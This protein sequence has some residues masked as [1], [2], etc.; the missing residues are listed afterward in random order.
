[1]IIVDEEHD[2]SFKQNEGLR[3]SA[4]DLSLVRGHL[5]QVPVVLGSATP[6]LESMHNAQAGRFSHLRLTQRAGAAQPPQISLVD[7]RLE[8]QQAGLSMTSLDA[9]DAC[10][11]RGEQA[12]VFIN[13]RGYAPSMLCQ[14]CGWSALCVRCDA[15]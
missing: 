10:L 11:G 2:A 14:D 3:Y 7:M 4:R 13:R 8:K 15:P 12:L 5:E 9:L 6:S 1:M